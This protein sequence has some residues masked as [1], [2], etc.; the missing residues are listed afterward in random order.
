ML[1]DLQRRKLRSVAEAKVLTGLD[2]E[3][4]RV[5]SQLFQLERFRIACKQSSR[6][7]K[8]QSVEIILTNKLALTPTPLSVEIKSCISARVK[9]SLK[10]S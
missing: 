10:P 9:M 1:R 7:K 6:N 4:T 8:N 5:L 3:V 2:H